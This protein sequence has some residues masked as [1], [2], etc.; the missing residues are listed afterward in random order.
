VVDAPAA[1][2]GGV[3]RGVRWQVLPALS[4]RLKS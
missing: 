4:G 3:K 2:L 1:V